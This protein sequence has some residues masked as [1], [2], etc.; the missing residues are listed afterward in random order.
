MYYIIDFTNI[1]FEYG[2]NIN[3]LNWNWL[4][5]QKLPSLP[6]GWGPWKNK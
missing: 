4:K 6:P 5:S 3:K 2:R 1:D